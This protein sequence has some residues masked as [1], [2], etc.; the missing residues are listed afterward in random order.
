MSEQVVE[1]NETEETISG[2][3]VEEEHTESVDEP[4][5]IDA[6]ISIESLQNKLRDADA[7]VSKCQDQMLRQQAE[8]DNIRKRLQRD[9]SDAHKF[10]LKNIANELLPIIDSM[11]MEQKSAIENPDTDV[12]TLREGS[13]LIMKMLSG[14]FEKFQIE[15]I[16]PEGDKF[17]PEKHQA[18]SMVPTPDVEPNTVIQVHQKGYE[19]NQRLLR[20][21]M[22]IV[23]AK[24]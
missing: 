7:E 24:S 21:A 20:P 15:V 6:D 23:A 10:A 9:V 19:L 16:D 11:E 14:L 5:E 17:D 22:V 3:I 8:V 1:N 18:I 12:T 4:I 13:A 2:E